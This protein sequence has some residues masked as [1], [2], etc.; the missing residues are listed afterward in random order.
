MER[1]HLHGLSANIPASKVV[2]SIDEEPPSTIRLK[3]DLEASR[4]SA[5]KQRE[6]LSAHKF[7]RMAFLTKYDRYR[8]DPKT[9]QDLQQMETE[10]GLHE[11]RTVWAGQR[12]R[13]RF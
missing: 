8:V 1:S 13:P 12:L 10:V 3:G 6:S 2:L 9:E 7:L 4:S 11:K 5:D